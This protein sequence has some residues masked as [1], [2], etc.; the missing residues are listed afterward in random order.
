LT[1]DVN[2]RNSKHLQA[3]MVRDER[4]F[5]SLKQKNLFDAMLGGHIKRWVSCSAWVMH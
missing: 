2:Y 4:D 5:N 3:C 1:Y